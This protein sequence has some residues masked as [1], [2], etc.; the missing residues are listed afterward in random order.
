MVV[1]DSGPLIHLSR[2][3]KIDLLRKLF[4]SISI[5]DCTYREVVE[6]GRALGKAGVSAVEQAIEEGWIRLAKL[7]PHDVKAAARLA[8]SESVDEGDAK[9]II[10]AAKLRTAL[11]TNDRLMILSARVLGVECLW[12]TS[13]LLRAVK[14]KALTASEAL[15][16]LRK[17]AETGLHMRL[18]VYESL[19]AAIEELG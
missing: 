16:V 11:V 14:A 17:L 5:T 19:R 12:T 8:R 18:E 10:L 13:L 4:T 9:A 6:E 3:G 7:E 1:C 2:I 15:L